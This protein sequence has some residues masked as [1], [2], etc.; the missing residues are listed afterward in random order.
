LLTH[1]GAVGRDEAAELIDR[2]VAGAEEHPQQR[3]LVD[4]ADDLELQ[5][6]A[7]AGKGDDVAHL[8]LERFE[9]VLINDDH[10]ALPRCDEAPR[11]H[12]RRPAQRLRVGADAEEHHPRREDRLAGRIERRDVRL[13]A[14]CHPRHARVG[15]ERRDQ[16]RRNGRARVVGTRHL[17]VDRADEILDERADRA[18]ERRVAAGDADDQR[19]RQRD[20]HHG[21][22]EARPPGEEVGEREP[23][24]VH[25]E[26]GAMVCGGRG[27]E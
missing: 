12:A 27:V 3:R 22:C 18:L 25:R 5:R 16:V 24:D 9:R 2:D 4:H 26:H 8:R 15:A 14:R 10:V 21:E 13:D 6:L 17:E 1:P 11:I 19:H 23:D 20:G 7:A